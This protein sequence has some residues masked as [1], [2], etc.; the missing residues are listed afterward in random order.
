[1]LHHLGRIMV[2]IENSVHMHTLMTKHIFASYTLISYIRQTAQGLMEIHWGFINPTII[3][4]ADLTKSL[5]DIR[6]SLQT[7]H[8]HLMIET[9]GD[10]YYSKFQ[11]MLTFRHNDF[12]FVT[13]QILVFETKYSLYHVNTFPIPTTWYS[14]HATKIN[15]LPNYFLI[16]THSQHFTSINHVEFQLCTRYGIYICTFQPT[17]KPLSAESCIS[18]LYFQNADGI[19]KLC[20]F[21]FLP[22]YIIPTLSRL[23]NGFIYA[24]N[25]SRITLQC[26]AKTSVTSCMATCLIETAN[27]CSISDNFFLPS[28]FN[29]K[30]H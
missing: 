9:D 22:D 4:H 19:H 14:K 3:S 10:F 16:S 29:H 18:A 30:P 8:P 23:P 5:I 25:I 15:N 7:M 6:N 27:G 2:N 12:I 21:T 20:Q 28:V 1:M 17:V 26:P 11:S 13:L 24:Q